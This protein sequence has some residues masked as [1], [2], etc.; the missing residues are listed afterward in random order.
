MANCPYCAFPVLIEDHQIAMAVLSKSDRKK[1]V[2]Q[3][4]VE[5]L[6][7]LTGCGRE[8]VARVEVKTEV[9]TYKIEGEN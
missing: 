5:P 4:P 3:C 2:L 8:F 9:R 1:V 7:K 6:P